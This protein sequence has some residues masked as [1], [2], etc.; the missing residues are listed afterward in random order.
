MRKPKFTPELIAQIPQWVA[1]NVP[2]DEIAARVGCKVSSL[3]VRCSQMKISLRSPNWKERHR[4][5]REANGTSKV[6][7]LKLPEPKPVAVRP[8]RRLFTMESSIQLS[9]VAMARLRQHADAMN[10]T[11]VELVT[12]L[13]E[14]IARD[15]LY[16]AVLDTKQKTAA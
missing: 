9:R 11:D 12:L 14:I 16:D 3:R 4:T 7:P 2:A 10:M 1:D 8:Q 5:T 6:Q 15:D 13:I